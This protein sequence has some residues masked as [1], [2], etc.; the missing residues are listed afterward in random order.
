[1]T[2]QV[3][4]QIREECVQNNTMQKIQRLHDWAQEVEKSTAEVLKWMNQVTQLQFGSKGEDGKEE[5]FVGSRTRA[6]EAATKSQGPSKPGANWKRAPPRD[7]DQSTG[8]N[9]GVATSDDEDDA[10]GE[11]G[12]KESAQGPSKQGRNL[13]SKAKP[14]RVATSDDE[15]KADGEAPKFKGPSKQGPNLKPKRVATS[16]NADR[17]V[18]GKESG[19]EDELTRKRKKAKKTAQAAIKNASRGKK[20]D[21]N[22]PCERSKQAN[23]GDIDEAIKKLDCDSLVG[24]GVEEAIGV[25]Q[26]NQTIVFGASEGNATL[27]GGRGKK[28]DEHNGGKINDEAIQNFTVTENLQAEFNAQLHDSF[29]DDEED[30][31]LESLL[32]KGR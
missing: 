20:A 26:G 2:D 10:D 28:A 30:Y 4:F 14:K 24:C 15:D 19:S 23:N 32:H 9:K 21:D 5:E 1:V 27:S 8:K 25:F 29:E 13:H 3:L 17:G 22:K 18:G 31:G 16:D 7:V 11:S 6:N 12:E